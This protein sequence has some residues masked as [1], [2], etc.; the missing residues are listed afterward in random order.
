VAEGVRQLRMLS[1]EDRLRTL[2]L[3]EAQL[4]PEKR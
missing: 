3:L 2:K 4:A 1:A